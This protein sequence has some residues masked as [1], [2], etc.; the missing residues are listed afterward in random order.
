MR[1][2][3][4]RGPELSRER[5]QLVRCGDDLDTLEGHASGGFP[6]APSNLGHDGLELVSE[7]CA[8][9]TTR[10]LRCSERELAGSPGMSAFGELLVQ[11]GRVPPYSH[12]SRQLRDAAEDRALSPEMRQ[13]MYVHLGGL[14]G[15][16]D[17]RSRRGQVDCSG[18][19]ADCRPSIQTGTADHFGS[20][21]IVRAGRWMFAAFNGVI[22][23]PMMGRWLSDSYR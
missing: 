18:T 7:S 6:S 22:T 1:R 15:D 13:S 23:G 16:C 21:E 4:C 2:A 20:V 5:E 8:P 10:Q 11:I 19:E 14:H 17:G 12:A 9:T 3:A